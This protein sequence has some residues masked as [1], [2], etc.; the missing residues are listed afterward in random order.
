[1]I[2]GLFG[3]P[4]VAVS[5]K[6]TALIGSAY[7]AC[8]FPIF[9]TPQLLPTGQPGTIGFYQLTAMKLA[10]DTNQSGNFF[11]V[12]VGGGANGIYD[13]MVNNNCGTPIGPTAATAPGNKIN[14]VID[15]FQWRIACATGGARPGGSP[16]CPAGPSACPSADVTAYVVNGDLNPAVN[17][18]NCTRLVIVPIFPDPFSGYN[19]HETVN[20]LGFSVFYISGVCTANQG[21]P[22]PDPSMGNQTLKKGTGWGY[23]VRMET[24]GTSIKPYDGFGTKAAV[25]CD[26]QC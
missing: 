23:Y 13:A 25:L 26:D 18:T 5:A 15:G 17:R 3:W 8:P 21:C 1:M 22:P 2:G 7:S 12:D 11:L 6:A 20:I 19:G 10:A 24:T 16:A 4:D 9:Q 14:K